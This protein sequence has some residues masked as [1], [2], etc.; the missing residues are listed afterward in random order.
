MNAV[1]FMLTSAFCAA[2]AP[3]AP[4]PTMAAPAPA[5]APVSAPAVISTGSACG[6]GCGTVAACDPCGKPSFLDKIKARF[7]SISFGHSSCGCEKPAPAPTCGCSKPTPVV[8]LKPLPTFHCKP[9]PTTACGC[10]AAPKVSI[11]DKIKGRLSCHK[12]SSC[13]TCGTSVPA[14]P[15][16]GAVTTIPSSTTPVAP[17]PAPAPTAPAAPKEMPKDAPKAPA[18]PKVG[19]SNVGGPTITPVSGS[20]SDSPF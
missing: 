6:G 15:C 20:K 12:V 18:A 17:A 9:A 13:E 1:V 8:A 10:E 2:D 16:A 3:P 5:P 11:F 7:S 14:S 19:L 4:A